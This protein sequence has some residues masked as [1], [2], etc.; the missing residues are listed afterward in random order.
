MEDGARRLEARAVA[1]LSAEAFAHV[2]PGQAYVVQGRGIVG[3]FVGYGVFRELDRAG[4]R[5]FV[6]E[7]DVQLRERSGVGR[8]RLPTLAVVS[9]PFRL[10]PGAQVV[11]RFDDGADPQRH[12]ALVLEPA[13]SA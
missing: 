7:S 4:V 3:A 12:F 9:G 1:H 13:P 2:E 11:A 8:R 6:A 10:R 5:V